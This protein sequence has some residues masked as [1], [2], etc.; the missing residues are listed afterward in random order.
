MADS[1]ENKETTA[2]SGAGLLGVV[3]TGMYDNPLPCIG[4]TYRMP[5]T[6]SPAKRFLNE[7]ESV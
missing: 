1:L 3:T 7:Q 4:S 2:L 6:R 5:L